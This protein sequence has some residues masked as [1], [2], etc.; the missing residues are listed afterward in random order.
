MI[1]VMALCVAFNF[2]EAREP[3]TA[4]T[5]IPEFVI[6]YLIT[7]FAHSAGA[8]TGTAVTSHGTDETSCSVST[9]E[10]GK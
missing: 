9:P 1:V 10:Y 7:L 8:N 4:A 3:C 6:S 2:A 5:A